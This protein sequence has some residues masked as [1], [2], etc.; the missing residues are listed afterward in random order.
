MHDLLF[1]VVEGGLTYCV[2][3]TDGTAKQIVVKDG[4][5][6]LWSQ[7]VKTDNSVGNLNGRYGLGIDDLNFDGYDD[8]MIATSVDGELISYDC[9]LRD[10]KKE[11]FVYS[12]ELSQIKTIGVKP[13]LKSVFGL[14][15]EREA[16]EGGAYAHCDKVTKYVWSNGKPMPEMYVSVTYNSKH[17][18]YRYSVAYYDEALKTFEDSN[19]VWM[20]PEEYAE[21]DWS[22]LYYYK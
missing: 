5:R 19:D 18:N 16:L 13:S 15:Q 14:T 20:T 4:D 7:S 8:V 22:F 9:Y 21:K 2:R 6:V 10:G 17:D 3:G 11:T 12:K 1:E